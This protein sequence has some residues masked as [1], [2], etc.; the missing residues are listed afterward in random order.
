MFSIIIPFK[1]DDITRLENLLSLIFY[2]EKNWTY[3]KI[4][5]VEMDEKP[6]I[7]NLLSD[8][9]IYLFAK[10]KKNEIWSRSKR[11]NFA[12]P[13]IKSQ[14]LMMLDSDVIIDFNTIKHIC[15][16]INNKEL[17]AATPFNKVFHMERN[18]LLN[19]M[20]QKEI[21]PNEFV[22]RNKQYILRE[23]I[24]NGGCFIAD[25]ATFKHLRGMNEL[26]Y[27]WGLEDDE[28]I[29]RY[30]KL[31]KKYGRVENICALHIE[32]KRTS[33]AVPNKECFA[34]NIIERHR[35]KTWSKEKIQEYYGIT[36]DA[37]AYSKLNK[38]ADPN[39]EEKI[40]I[41]NEKK[42]YGKFFE[43]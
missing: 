23:F 8:N 13:I 11:I 15:E 22:E 17:D 28:L 4:I 34:G 1:N 41:Q 43:E 7:Y 18:I 40:I 37:G 24:A 30:M 2:I 42:L 6:T 27:G 31:G 9:I 3:E 10:E 29:Y 14:I 36:E 16:K 26:F 39:E 20:Q 21:N 35:I 19:A 33:N 38:P 32:H 5:V 25:T 12:L